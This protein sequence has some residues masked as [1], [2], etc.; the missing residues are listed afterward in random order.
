MLGSQERV[1]RAYQVSTHHVAVLRPELGSS[2]LYLLLGIA[3][4]S[5]ARRGRVSAADGAQQP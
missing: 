4:P 3:M 1:M 5:N 2:P